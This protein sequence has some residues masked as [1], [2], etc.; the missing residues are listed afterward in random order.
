MKIQTSAYGKVVPLVYGTT[1]IAPNL[2]WYGDFVATPHNSGSSGGG[3]GKGGVTGGGGGKGGGSDGTTTY[4]YSAAVALGLCEGPIAG[5]GTVWAAKTET[6]LAALGLGLFDGAYGQAP[7]S[8]LSSVHP[9]Q[10]LGYSGTAYVAGAGY[11]LDDGAQLPNHNMEVA[12][13][14]AG[15]APGMPDADPSQV[16]AD[17]LTNPLFGA[18]FPPAR[19]GSLAIYQA[20]RS[21]PASGSR[22][23][24]PSRRKHRKRSTT[25]RASRTALSSG[26]AACSALVPYGDEP[27]VG[28]RLQL[29]AAIG[30]ALRSWR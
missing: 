9:D 6:S 18:G 4:T 12:G 15:S 21:P 1:R 2:I 3:G 20:T 22:R 14:L 16:I 19:L 24:I 30:A 26:R 23:P 17:L 25:S 11:Q 8:Y 29:H 28:E 27:L 10:A 5:I 13:F 7:W